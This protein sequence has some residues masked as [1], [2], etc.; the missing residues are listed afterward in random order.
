MEKNFVPTEESLLVIPRAECTDR[1]DDSSDEYMSEDLCEDDINKLNNQSSSK[2][3]EAEN[4]SSQMPPVSVEITPSPMVQ[5]NPK[6]QLNR[7]GQSLDEGYPVSPSISSSNKSSEEQ[8]PDL[9]I[10]QV[11]CQPDVDVDLLYSRLSTVEEMSSS[12]SGEIN[13]KTTLPEVPASDPSRKY[14]G[15]GARPKHFYQSQPGAQFQKQIG[16]AGSWMPHS[17]TSPDLNYLPSSSSPLR[18]SMTLPNLNTNLC[19]GRNSPVSNKQDMPNLHK[20]C[21]YYSASPS[22]G[23]FDNG[24]SNFG[25]L[26]SSEGDSQPDFKPNSKSSSRKSSTGSRGV[27]DEI[28]SLQEGKVHF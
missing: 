26:G 19:P 21:G 6:H 14:E 13:P 11:N 16:I 3:L 23:L 22:P 20:S 4:V 5:A 2:S 28:R 12:Q 27:D 10:F 24:S 8:L 17:M 9:A 15:T 1:Y 18:T 25:N 7:S